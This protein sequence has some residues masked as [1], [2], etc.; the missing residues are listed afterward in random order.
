MS[1]PDEDLTKRRD[2]DFGEPHPDPRQAHSASE[3]L[4]DVEG[5]VEIEAVTY[6]VL[7]VAYDIRC[8]TLMEI[9][10]GLTAAGF[11]LDNGLFSKLRR[12]ICYYAEDTQRAN[13]GCEQGSSNCTR[14]VFVNRYNQRQHGCRDERP[15]HWRRYL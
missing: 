5:V 9:E 4:R 3:F 6:L 8:I 15:Q 11:Q 7:R 2:I 12:A 1:E 10:K 13:M 14:R